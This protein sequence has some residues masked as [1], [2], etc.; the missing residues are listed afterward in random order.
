MYRGRVG[1]CARQPVRPP[2]IPPAL[3]RRRLGSFSSVAT[4]SRWLDEG[5]RRVRATDSDR[6]DVLAQIVWPS[7]ELD[8]SYVLAQIVWPSP[9]LDAS[10]AV[11]SRPFSAANL[12]RVCAGAPSRM[13]GLDSQ[14][15]AGRRAERPYRKSGQRTG[16]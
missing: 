11:P 13:L 5:S 1:G 15:R 9:E 14:K 4:V 10:Y 6:F 2:A 3:P 12:D 16:S 7:P 8:A